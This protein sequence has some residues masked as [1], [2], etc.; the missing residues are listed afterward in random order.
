MH[1]F[2]NPSEIVGLVVPV[3]GVGVEGVRPS[4]VKIFSSSLVALV[5]VWIVLV[6]GKSGFNSFGIFGLGVVD[7]ISLTQII[8]TA[9][10]DSL[11]SVQIGLPHCF[12]HAFIQCL[13]SQIS[14]APQLI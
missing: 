10:L 1:F 7:S 13:L 11:R 6:S 14:C 12:W 2:V 4:V 3:T 8:L 9:R 5:V